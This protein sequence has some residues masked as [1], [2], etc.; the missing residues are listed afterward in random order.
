MLADEDSASSRRCLVLVA[1]VLPI[2]QAEHVSGPEVRGRSLGTTVEPFILPRCCGQHS[3]PSR[4]RR[5]PDVVG[6][7]PYICDL[8]CRV[9]VRATFARWHNHPLESR[10]RAVQDQSGP[11]TPIAHA[12]ALCLD[13]L[14]DRGRKAQRDEGWRIVIEQQIRTDNAQLSPAVLTRPVDTDRGSNNLAA[15]SRNNRGSRRDCPK[16]F[17]VTAPQMLESARLQ[18]ALLGCP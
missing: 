5:S 7:G 6:H 14:P 8:P 10:A 18:D 9:S 17:L 13:V 1:A 11:Q 2:F 12:R 4:A 3:T 16:T 15:L